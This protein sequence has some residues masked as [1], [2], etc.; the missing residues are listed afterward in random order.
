M[1]YQHL[2]DEGSS[3]KPMT[4][5]QLRQTP[6]PTGWEMRIDQ[7]SGKVYF[8][9]HNTQ[10]TTWFDPRMYPPPPPPPSYPQHNP[11]SDSEKKHTTVVYQPSPV[12]LFVPYYHHGWGWGC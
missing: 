12:P 6:L 10:T 7:S 9:D 1:S 4:E 3:P 2:H 11:H 5:E 8:V